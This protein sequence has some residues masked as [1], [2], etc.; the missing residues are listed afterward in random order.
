M[1]CLLHTL[2]PGWLIITATVIIAAGISEDP[3]ATRGKPSAARLEPPSFHL[4]LDAPV[5][6]ANQCVSLEGV[7]SLMQR[8]QQLLFLQGAWQRQ[9]QHNL[10]SLGLGWRYF[11]ES[12]WGMGYHLFYDQEITRRQRRIGLGAEAWWQSLTLA[13]NSYLPANGWRVGGDLTGYHQ[14]PAN[15]YEVTLRG[16]LPTLPH[17]G[18]SVR[19]AHYLG[20]KVALGAAPPYRNQQQWR[21]GIDYTPI[22]LLTLAYRR[23]AGLSGHA[24]QRFSMVLNYRFGRPL[25]KQLDPQQV[26]LLYSAG[27]RRLARVRRDYVMVLEYTKRAVPTAPQR[28]NDNDNRVIATQTESQQ[29]NHP[30][31]T[32]KTQP[33]P[34][35]MPPPPPPLPPDD[36]SRQIKMGRHLKKTGP[37]SKK[38]VTPR[39]SLHNELLE[40]LK[41]SGGFKFKN[42]ITPN[43]R[44][45]IG[46]P[47]SLSQNNPFKRLLKKPDL[48]GETESEIKKRRLAFSDSDHLNEETGDW[49]ALN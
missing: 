37:L 16:I 35:P 1:N 5:E 11:P 22:P 24:K 40:K 26:N 47:K 31:T 27:R 42:K 13:V 7:G 15:G 14:R 39:S 29:H 41:K 34:P 32:A 17:L 25:L 21:W 48:L 3:L 36:L 23:Q 30:S 6:E 43:K 46:T 18:A 10:L 12:H 38:P 28:H 2:L 19:Y 20:D 45:K 33:P 8:E 44:K 4:T 49:S 9:Q